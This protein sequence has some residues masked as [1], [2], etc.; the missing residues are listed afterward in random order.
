MCADGGF[1]AIH[2]T[3]TNELTRSWLEATLRS[4]G[5]AALGGR[6]ETVSLLEPHKM[7][8]N[9]ITLLQRRDGGAEAAAGGGYREPIYSK[10]P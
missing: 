1:V 7:W 2:S 9:S 6:F 4:G 8:Q 10:F 5:P 3:L